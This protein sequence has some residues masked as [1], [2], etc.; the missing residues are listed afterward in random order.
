MIDDD[1]D[2]GHDPLA[3]RDPHPRDQIDLW[4]L[5][6]ARQELLEEIVSQPGPGQSA[7]VRRILIP[8]GLAAAVAL[9]I[10]VAWVAV[11]SDDPG[12]G[13]DDQVVALE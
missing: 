5:H 9:V 1:P 6:D 12:R 10:G 2:P 7:P 3:G 8:V 13:K 11:S 4:P